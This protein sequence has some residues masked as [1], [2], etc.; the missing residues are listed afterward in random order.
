M[1]I[2]QAD[3]FEMFLSYAKEDKAFVEKLLA[4]L[5][6]L[7]NQGLITVWHD[8]NI[9]PGQERTKETNHHLTTA[10]IILLLISSDFMASRV[11]SE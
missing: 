4:H 7:R 1:P 9:S 3:A 11:S 6:S 2:D 5:S 8:Q 10:P